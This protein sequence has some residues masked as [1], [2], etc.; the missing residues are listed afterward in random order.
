MA[1]G[2]YTPPPDEYVRPKDK[3]WLRVQGF[4]FDN[5]YVRGAT[6]H[7]PALVEFGNGHALD[8]ELVP[9]PG[10]PHDPWAVAFHVFG[11]RI[12][13]L[14]SDFADEMHEYVAGHNRRDRA[15]FAAGEVRVRPEDGIRLATVFLPWWPERDVFQADSGVPAECDALLDTLPDDVRERVMQTSQNLSS[16]DVRLIRSRKS[17]APHLVW[18]KRAGNQIPVALRLRLIDLDIARQEEERRSRDAA[19]E[20][21]RE[22]KRQEREAKIE[23]KEAFDESIRQLAR[24]GV[25]KTAIAAKLNCSETK[26][27]ST[28][29]RAG[30]STANANETSRSERLKR[31]RQAL[32]LQRDG[33][34]RK[35][36]A[37]AFGCGFETVK[38]LLKDAKFFEEPSSDFER[39]QR[40]KEVAGAHQFVKLSDAAAY[41]GWAIKAVKA[42]RSDA[43]VL[44]QLHP[45]FDGENQLP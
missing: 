38:D 39:Q 2:V 1:I 18:S 7:Q 24:E 29:Q 16:D 8:V 19:R 31:S 44:G 10:N 15:V 43:M 4:N 27:R 6:Y 23:A 26:V 12:G 32:A 33:F 5:H 25:S 3:Y 14:A 30:L 35:E 34:T 13:Y 11:Q 9:E 36:I 22:A 20:L 37:Q 28:L 17:S 40:A 42:A 41:L 21:A 45:D